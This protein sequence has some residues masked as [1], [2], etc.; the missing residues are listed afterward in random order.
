M[1]SWSI[2]LSDN[3]II[4]QF[5][6]AIACS[7]SRDEWLPTFG[8]P[9]LLDTRKIRRYE[10]VFPRVS[11]WPAMSANAPSVTVIIP[12]WNAEK[13]ISRAIQSVLDQDYPNL[14]TIV[15]DDGSTDNSLEIVK[16]FGD[17]VRWQ[18]GPNRGACVARNSG[19]AI[20]NSNYVIFLDADD[21]LGPAYFRCVEF[22]SAPADIELFVGCR[23]NAKLGQ[24][25]GPLV[26]PQGSDWNGLVEEI[27]A[28][29][30]MQTSQMIFRRE[31]IEKIGGWNPE[32]AVGQDIELSLRA[33]LG[34]PKIRSL[35]PSS[36]SVY[37]HHDSAFRITKMPS[38]RKVISLANIYNSL[39]K[40]VARCNDRRVC[41]GFGERLYALARLLM[42]IHDYDG[43][44]T[45]LLNA[46]RLGV[47][48][49]VGSARHIVL[50]Y[51]F[52]F[53]LKHRVVETL[54][55]AAYRFRTFSGSRP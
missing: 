53:F 37:D 30:C 4:R 21:E 55:A 11:W 44:K 39:T 23:L 36:Y 38:D 24:S 15:I 43:A 2:G 49:H 12:C 20:A 52:G 29:N 46:R 42:S 25:M 26:R 7:S 32:I 33:L 54:K 34:R 5:A 13:W 6:G 1:P 50:S 14:E 40:L 31:F 19:L 9:R 27:I 48:G 16:S 22:T 3:D 41:R 17:K 10:I 8:R 47:K 45:C 18:T 51:M 35:P 28:G